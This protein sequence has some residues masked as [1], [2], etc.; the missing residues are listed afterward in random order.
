MLPAFDGKQFGGIGH[1]F[2][3]VPR[4]REIASDRSGVRQ[5]A[6]FYREP[7][8]IPFSVREKPDAAEKRSFNA[9]GICSVLRHHLVIEF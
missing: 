9:Y 5:A 6:V 8:R 4:V 2:R 7:W 1:C 3:A